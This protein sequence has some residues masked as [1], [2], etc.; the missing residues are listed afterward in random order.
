MFFNWQKADEEKIEAQRELQDL[1]KE[2]TELKQV[3]QQMGDRISQQ[4]L[5]VRILMDHVYDKDEL[6]KHL[7]ENGMATQ[8]LGLQEDLSA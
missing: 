2:M 5:L 3:N 4:N 6:T 7:A 8:E 1:E